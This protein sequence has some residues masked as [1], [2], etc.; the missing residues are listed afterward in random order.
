[1]PNPLGLAAT[2]LRMANARLTDWIFD[3]FPHCDIL[4]HCGKQVYTT[5]LAL[6]SFYLSQP[7]PKFI[8]KRL[9][10]HNLLLINR[11]KEVRTTVR[12]GGKAQIK[13]FYI[14]KDIRSVQLLIC[15]SKNP[16]AI[17]W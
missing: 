7:P 6:S 10:F 17:G 11:L 4:P 14:P 2:V 16:P 8:I 3:I 9:Q 13:L 5:Y 12:G 15:L 1:M